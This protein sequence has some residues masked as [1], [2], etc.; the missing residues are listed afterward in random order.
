MYTH[1]SIVGNKTKLS[2][3]N[4][5]CYCAHALVCRLSVTSFQ[6]VTHSPTKLFT[7]L[8]VPPTLTVSPENRYS[9]CLVRDCARRQYDT[10]FHNLT[11]P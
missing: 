1:R 3:L 8:D 6:V 5:M 2:T 9:H 7:R 4:I 10:N 11:N